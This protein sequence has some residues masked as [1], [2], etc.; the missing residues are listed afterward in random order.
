MV[1]M[2]RRPVTA[3]A[4]MLAGVAI[5]LQRFFP[6]VGPDG[7][8]II[9]ITVPHAG[10][11]ELVNHFPVNREPDSGS[12][13]L[14]LRHIE[15][16]HPQHSSRLPIDHFITRHSGF[17]LDFA[18]IA[19]AVGHTDFLQQF[20]QFD[21]RLAHRLGIVIRVKRIE[22]RTRSFQIQL[23]YPIGSALMQVDRLRMDH[24]QRG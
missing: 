10:S 5:P 13:K 20:D 2:Q 6:L 17:H 4:A 12:D 8:V 21:L 1:H 22:Q 14:R 18:V 9:I 19:A 3:D 24:P 16:R 11:L 7:A 23:L 15:R